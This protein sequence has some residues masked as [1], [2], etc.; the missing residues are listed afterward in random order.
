MEDPLD[1]FRSRRPKGNRKTRKPTRSN[2]S[3]ARP[4]RLT[5]QRAIRHGL[6]SRRAGVI[7]YY[8]ESS[9]QAPGK[10]EIIRAI[11]SLPNIH[12][13][14]IFRQIRLVKQHFLLKVGGSGGDTFDAVA[15]F[16]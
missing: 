9:A 8:I 5:R 7:I 2:L 12:A 14:Q 1:A 13:L 16:D 11:G 3:R 6:V 4:G 15:D 10:R